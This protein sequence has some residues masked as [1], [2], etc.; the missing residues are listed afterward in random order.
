MHIRRFLCLASVLTVLCAHANAQ[1]TVTNLHPA[2]A[3]QSFAFGVSGANQAG[4]A[5]VGGVIRASL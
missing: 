4:Q 5:A 3:T 1:W 2:G